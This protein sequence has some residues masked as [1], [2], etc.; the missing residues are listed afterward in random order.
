M[1]RHDIPEAMDALWRR[2]VADGDYLKDT[3]IPLERMH[4]FISSL[5]GEDRAAAERTLADWALSDDDDRR[6]VAQA[7]ID[8][9][10]VRDAIPALEA[11]SAR[12]ATRPGP[13]ARGEREIVEKLIAELQATPAPQRD[14]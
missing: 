10:K 1:T 6:F 8:D 7:M 5:A 12:L 4:G 9:F 13:L 2:G 11:L 14:G 3:F